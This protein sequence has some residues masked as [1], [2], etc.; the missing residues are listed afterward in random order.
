MS[1]D[2]QPTAEE[3]EQSP[4]AEFDMEFVRLPDGRSIVPAE[5]EGK[6]V[7]LVAFGAMTEQCFHEMRR[8]LQGIVG[9]GRWRQNWPSPKPHEGI[10]AE[11][12]TQFD[13]EIRPSLPDGAAILPDETDGRFVWLVAAGAMTRRCFE[14]MRGYLLH[15]VSSGEWT[16]DRGRPQPG[17]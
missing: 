12:V 15:I 8:H 7:F 10:N 6:F 9:T 14:E 13:M 11:P 1:D 3:R 5:R 4:K 17:H 16:Q 2:A